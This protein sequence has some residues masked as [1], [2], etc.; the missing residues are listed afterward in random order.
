MGE[1]E[2]V[3]FLFLLNASEA[4][5]VVVESLLAP[6]GIPVQ[7]RYSGIA[8][9]AFVYGGASAFGLS[10]YVPGYMLEQALSLLEAAPAGEDE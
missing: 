5:A 10:L 4:E 7:R 2:V 6:E 3:E 1:K 9:P 8:S